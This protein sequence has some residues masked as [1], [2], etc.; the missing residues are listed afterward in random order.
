MT[1]LL[2][3]SFIPNNFQYLADRLLNYTLLMVNGYPH[4]IC[5]VEFYLNSLEHPDNYVHRHIDQTKKGTLYFH[6]HTNGTYKSGTFK[7]MDIVFGSEKIYGTV[8]VRSV[9]DINNKK[10][11]EGP[12][13][14][15]EHMLK[16]C[17]VKS[18]QE[19]T[20]NQSLNFLDKSQ[21]IILID[22]DISTPDQIFCGPRYGLSD[23]Y[24]EY[25]DKP[26]RFALSIV[27]KQK[28]KL[29]LLIK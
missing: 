18:I 9:F 16:L 13:N 1:S 21:K 7:G 27:K 11:I 17:D 10:F 3:T 26:Y 28:K 24:S 23:K 6:R 12:C 19:L 5:E 20:L 15:V 14:T 22:G 8:L 29:A 2:K 25:K 4:R